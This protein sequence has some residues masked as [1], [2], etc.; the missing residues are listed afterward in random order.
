MHTARRSIFDPGE[1]PPTIFPRQQCPFGVS[2][3][4]LGAGGVAGATA[5]SA[6]V[7][8]HLLTLF[9]AVVSDPFLVASSFQSVQYFR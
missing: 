7:L 5:L 8:F 3:R 2:R 6:V 1:R 9:R 4:D